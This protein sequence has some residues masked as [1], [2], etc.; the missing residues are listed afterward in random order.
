MP[1]PQPQTPLLQRLL[2]FTPIYQRDKQ[3]LWHLDIYLLLASS[4]ILLLLIGAIF[5]HTWLTN[6]Q[7]TL[8]TEIAQLNQQTQTL[9]KHNPSPTFTKTP[10]NLN[11][12]SVIGYLSAQHLNVENV[13]S[14]E[15]NQ[16]RLWKAEGQLSKQELTPFMRQLDID[17]GSL[18][19]SEFHIEQTDAKP[20]QL[21][22]SL[23][24]YLR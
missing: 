17:R 7:R 14:V 9:L 21:K 13:T 8:T 5:Y 18:N 22:I 1:Q 24:G 20:N 16:Q 15:S 12:Q 4:G 10:Q 6:Q 11:L 2:K 23:S 19:L 3:G